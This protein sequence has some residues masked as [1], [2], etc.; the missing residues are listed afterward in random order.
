MQILDSFEKKAWS[1]WELA[2]NWSET[3]PIDAIPIPIYSSD[4]LPDLS[5][6]F[7]A[8]GLLNDTGILNKW[9]PDF[10]AASPRGDVVVDYFADAREFNTV[11]DDQAPLRD[12]MLNISNGG[13]QKVGTERVFREFPALLS[14]LPLA[15]FSALFGDYFSPEKIGL[16]L[17]VPI[18]YGRGQHERTTRTDTHCEPIGNAMLMLSG[19]KKWLL[20]PPSQSTLL[21]PQVAPD[22]RGYVYATR[23]PHDKAIQSLQRYEILVEAGDVLWVPCWYWHRVE[24][25]PDVAALSVSMFHFR[26]LDFV[27]ANPQ[28][29]V[30]LLPNLIKE[31]LGFKMQ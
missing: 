11:P 8:R 25:I 10:F 4:S 6:P 2:A 29:A 16:Q 31:L 26:P 12:V 23:D 5:R 14:E 19:R 21:R 20:L 24:Y 9:T 17:T 22:G 7:I 3:E 30:A 18:F 27:T 1:N 28:F 13:Y 15:W